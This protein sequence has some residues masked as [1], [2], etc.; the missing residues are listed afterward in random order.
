[1]QHQAP[2][3]DT[4]MSSSSLST[5]YSDEAPPRRRA[6]VPIAC[7]QCRHRRIRV[8]LVF[9]LCHTSVL[10]RAQCQTKGDNT[11]C[12]RCVRRN[13]VCEYIPV[14]QTSAA[15]LSPANGTHS[16]SVSHSSSVSGTDMSSHSR[17]VDGHAPSMVSTSVS[18]NPTLHTTSA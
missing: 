14:S 16:R 10:I 5:S 9:Q 4:H 17:R 18:S 12:Q 7:T 6:R 2:I 11:P 15:N 1:M 3:P 8:C 13:F